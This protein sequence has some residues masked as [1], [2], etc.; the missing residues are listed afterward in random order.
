MRPILLFLLLSLPFVGNAQYGTFED[1]SLPSTD[2]YYVNFTNPGKDVGFTEGGV[3]YPCV[4]DTSGGYSFWSSGFVYSNKHDSVTSGYQ[5]QF[6]AKPGKGVNNSSTYAVAYGQIN[7]IKKNLPP[8]WFYYTYITNTTYAFNSMRDGDGFA[9]K[10]G[11]S[12][13]NDPDWFLLTIRAYKNGSRVGKDSVDFYLADFRFSNNAQDYIVNNW[14]QVFFPTSF[15]T[16][17]SLTFSLRSSDT[18]S[19]GI[20][21]PLYFCIDDFILETEG[22]A[23]L[24]FS[25]IASIAP[26]PS[27]DFLN[28]NISK[29]GFD[30][31]EILSMTGSKIATFYLNGHSN[32]ININ[33]LPAGQYVIR[34]SGRGGST[35]TRFIK[36]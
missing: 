27:T 10:F 4:F 19:F 7:G 29:D 31:V 33:Q 17:D 26:I 22:V 1:L 6:S 25:T 16:A 21:T 18:G 30:Q 5:N 23:T 14:K 32:R 13:G 8:L 35:S 24:Q 9:K 36:Q 15:I 20:N 12:S 3:H 11:G 34:L 28:L 2:T